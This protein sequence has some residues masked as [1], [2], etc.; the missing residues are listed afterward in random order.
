MTARD[1]NSAT[2]KQ[3]TKRK[4][5]TGELYARRPDAELQIGKVG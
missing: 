2:I 4:R 5:E 1:T 3:L